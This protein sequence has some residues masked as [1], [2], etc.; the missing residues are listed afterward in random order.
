MTYIRCPRCEL[1][2]IEKKQKFCNVCKSEMKASGEIVDESEMKLCPA[3]HTSL[4]PQT[5]DICDSCR[6]ELGDDY[7][8]E[9]KKG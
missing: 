9:A 6:E 8:L 5:Q 2:Y 3:C 4:I 7:L 1:N